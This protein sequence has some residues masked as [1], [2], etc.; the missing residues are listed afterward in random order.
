MVKISRIVCPVD[1]SAFPEGRSRTAHCAGPA[2]RSSC[3]GRL[4]D[5]LRNRRGNLCLP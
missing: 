1:F 4:A 5:L 2:P 3:A